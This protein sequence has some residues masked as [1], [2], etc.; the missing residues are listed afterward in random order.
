MV[1]AQAVD[2]TFAEPPL[3]LHMGGVENRAVL[4]P[5]PGK[6]RDRKKA[7]VAAETVAP[8][9]QPVVPVVGGIARRSRVVVGTQDRQDYSAVGVEV[10]VDIKVGR[11]RRR[12]AV[13]ENVVP[14]PV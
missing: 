13:L 11:V 8:S 10:P 5:Q 9:D 1:D 14:P 4:L 2:E 7:P 3:D 6:G 12:T